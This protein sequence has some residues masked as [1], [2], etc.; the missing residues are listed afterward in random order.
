MEPEA[1]VEPASY[2]PAADCVRH[3]VRV[4]GY[5]CDHSDDDGG[6]ADDGDGDHSDDGDG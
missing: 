6:G 5:D 4:Q 1:V 3:L 2:A